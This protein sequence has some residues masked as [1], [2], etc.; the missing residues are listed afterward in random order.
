MS[1]QNPYAEA[2]TLSVIVFG[3]EAFGEVIRFR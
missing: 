1:P 3:G 2:L